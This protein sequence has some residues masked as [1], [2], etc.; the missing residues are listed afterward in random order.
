MKNPGQ[1]PF[2]PGQGVKFR[3]G[4]QLCSLASWPGQIVKCVKV[5]VV[6][7]I[8]MHTSFI[9]HIL[10]STYGYICACQSV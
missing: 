10:L 7:S 6:T 2:C 4:W 5:G 9:K 8:Y 3:D 1:A